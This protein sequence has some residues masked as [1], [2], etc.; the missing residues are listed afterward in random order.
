M[1]SARLRGCLMNASRVSRPSPAVLA[2]PRRQ[3]LRPQQA[4]F[5]TGSGLSKDDIQTRV[6]DI[7]KSFEKVDESKVCF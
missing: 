5:A 4:S 1:F 2:V 7:L 6:L 3:W